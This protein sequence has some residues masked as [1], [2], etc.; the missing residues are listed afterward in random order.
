MAC[1]SEQLAIG[2][3]FTTVMDVAGA[4]TPQLGDRALDHL[5]DPNACAFDLFAEDSERHAIAGI[6][7]SDRFSGFPRD[8][9]ERD[10]HGRLLDQLSS[11]GPPR[12]LVLRSREI[13]VDRD[14]AP[15]L[16]D[17]RERATRRVETE[18]KRLGI[19][20][21]PSGDRDRLPRT[22]DP[23]L[24]LCRAHDRR[25]AVAVE[26]IDRQDDPES[27]IGLVRQLHAIGRA[28]VRNDAE[29]PIE[30]VSQSAE[31]AADLVV[32]R[33]AGRPARDRCQVFVRVR[34]NL[35]PD[36]LLL[37]R[38]PGSPPEETPVIEYLDL[39]IDVATGRRQRVKRH[40]REGESKEDH[41]LFRMTHETPP[42]AQESGAFAPPT[43][44]SL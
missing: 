10:V 44:D 25:T 33:A 5:I 12:S 28:D 23:F 7:K 30:A 27:G 18:L 13:G 9:F 6:A 17:C 41:D 37:R 35:H 2:R 29:Q 22:Q 38:T 31:Q 8:G 42:P 34:R 24:V 14:L 43:G 32:V 39:H 16:V 4:Q 15:C 36:Q 21:L 40:Q 3:P 11:R 1:R 20:H 19:G 26:S